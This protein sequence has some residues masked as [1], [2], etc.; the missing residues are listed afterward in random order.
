MGFDYLSRVL[1]YAIGDVQGCYDELVEL[2]DLIDFDPTTDR[3][4]FTGD[5]VNRGPKSLDV[6]RCVVA[7]GDAAITVLGNHDLSLIAAA[8]GHRRQRKR[9][10]RDGIDEVLDAPDAAALVEWL[11]HRPLVHRAREHLLVHAGVLPSWS[12]DD[13]VARA[14]EVEAA[15]RGD[16]WREL[17][18]NM[19]GDEPNAWRE[20]LAGYERLR[21]TINACTRM[22]FCS[23]TGAL[24][25]SANGRAEDAPPGLTPWFR[26]PDRAAADTV[27]VCGHWAML[28]LYLTPSVL[29][30]DSGCVWGGELTALRLEDRS[31]FQVPS[32]TGKIRV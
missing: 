32:R 13:V 7:L 20:S 25:L 12:A 30:I 26:V 23:A 18:A 2:L 21:L 27:V 17:C 1:T 11:R 3:I 22:R 10:N 31:V 14:R 28:G 19:Y 29:H 5:L 4:W 9:A 16:A 8:A 24:D 15:L 6:I